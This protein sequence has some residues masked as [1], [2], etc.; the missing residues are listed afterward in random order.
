MSPNRDTPRF[1]QPWHLD[2]RFEAELPEDRVVGTRFLANAAYG[3]VTGL[4]LLS[5]FGL[6]YYD[7]GLRR[8]IGTIESHFAASESE[9]KKVEH[10]Q[11]EYARES[12]KVDQAHA[13]MQ[14]PLFVAGF[15]TELGR[16]RPERMTIDIIDSAEPTTVVVRGSLRE[17]SERASRL[18]DEYLETLRQNPQ[19]KPRC[20]EILLTGL[21]R[22]PTGDEFLNFEITFRLR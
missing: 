13:L 20:R 5:C 7:L 11:A 21:D 14:M 16:S 3:A 2:C 10:L 4:L 22:S 12:A 1:L 19:I 18:L 15:V 9:V 8:D 17:T 6:I